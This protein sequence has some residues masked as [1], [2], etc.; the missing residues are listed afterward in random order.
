MVKLRILTSPIRGESE[1]TQLRR[2]VAA[3]LF[4][5]ENEGFGR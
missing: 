3:G 2:V 1:V 4:F 5:A